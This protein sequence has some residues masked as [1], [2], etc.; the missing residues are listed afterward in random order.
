MRSGN[1][2][3]LVL[4]RVVT[5]SGGQRGFTPRKALDTR[6]GSCPLNPRGEE[7]QGTLHCFCFGFELKFFFFLALFHNYIG[8]IRLLSVCGKSG[9]KGKCF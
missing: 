2:G 5:P 9:R 4:H 3:A 8:F 1:A 7:V 6:A